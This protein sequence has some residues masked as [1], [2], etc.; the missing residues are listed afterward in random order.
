MGTG[1]GAEQSTRQ[2]ILDAAFALFARQGFHGTSMRQIA[3]TSGTAL[4]GIYNHF[5]SKQQLFEILIIERH[6]VLPVLEILAETPGE[7]VQVFFQNA[8]SLIQAEMANQPGFINLMLVE[9][10][11]FKSQHLPMLIKNFLPRALAIFERLDVELSEM[12]ELPAREVMFHFFIT[13]LACNAAAYFSLEEG[14]PVLETQLDIFF[15]GIVNKE[16]A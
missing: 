8:A 3:D 10:T 15:N 7:T 6:P 11:E 5:R 2:A 13:L 12:R 4:G 1:P 16:D 14:L 9:I